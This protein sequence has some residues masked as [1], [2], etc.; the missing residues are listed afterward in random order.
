MTTF[1]SM[2]PCCI[3]PPDLL[4][5]VAERGTPAEREAALK[6]LAT[7]E[8]ARAQRASFGGA[9]RQLNLTLSDI[10]P[11]PGMVRTVYDVENGGDFGL[12]GRKRRGEGEQR[13]VRAAWQQVGGL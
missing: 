9:L 11:A 1:D 13:K 4:A 3:A 6:T 12:P 8:S 7:S 10:E 2:P 5:A